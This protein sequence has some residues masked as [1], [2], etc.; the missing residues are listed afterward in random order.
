MRPTKLIIS[1]FGPYASRSEI[2]L[3]KLGTNGLFLITGDTGAGKTTI[4]DAIAFA[5]YGK[6]SGSNRDES[7]LRSKYA[8]P[9]TPT[10]VELTFIYGGKEYRI[11]RNPEYERPKIHGM[12]TTME[13]S[14]AELY[15]P[16][17]P[18]ISGSKEVT[19]AVIDIMGVDRD[20]YTQIAM[21]AQGDFLKLL[22]AT[23]DE[24]KK[25]FQKIFRTHTYYQLQELLKSES[26]KLG[27]EY[28]MV[29]AGIRQYVNGIVCHSEDSLN[30]GI[31]KAK[32]GELTMQETL[33]LLSEL[34]EKESLLEED[35]SKES[36]AISKLLE[37]ITARIA[38]AE[39]CE[40]ARKSIECHTS[41]L[42]TATKRLAE[43][44]AL[45]ESER[46]RA[47]ACAELTLKIAS[48]QAQ[49]DEYSER[50]SKMVEEKQLG[51]QL[52]GDTALLKSRVEKKNELLSLCE[53]LKTEWRSLEGIE[54]DKVKAEAEREAVTKKN[55]ICIELL[56]EL[57]VLS[58]I[59]KELSDD[60]D[61]YLRLRD[62]AEEIKRQY[63]SRYRLYLDG[64]AG[65]LA[66]ELADG[67]ACPV[68]GSFT[69][70]SPAV[71]P[72]QVPTKDELDKSRIAA[73]TAREK[74]AKASEKASKTKGRADEKQK[75]VSE[76]LLNEFGI[77][78]LDT[79]NGQLSAILGETENEIKRIDE[80][81]K[82]VSDKIARRK[83]IDVE[84]SEKEKLIS[85]SDEFIRTTNERITATQTYLESLRE[86]IS[87]LSEKLDFA[88]ATEATAEKRRLEQEKEALELSLK[89]AERNV[90]NQ[91]TVISE[92]KAKISEAEKH[93]E[94]AEDTDIE[95]AREEY[96]SL[97]ER[98]TAL[99]TKIKEIHAR[100]VTNKSSEKNICQ[101]SVEISRIEE[102]WTWIKA[103]SNTARGNLSGKD[104]TML[105]TY[106]QKTYFDRIIARANKRLLIMTGGQYEL[107]RSDKAENKKSQS[108][109][110]L[111]VKDH[112]N[113]TERSVKSLSGGES[114]MAS[115]ALA[116]GLSEEIQASAGGI[117]L[118]TM[119]VDE[120]FGSLDE[121]SLAQ[122]IK[123][124]MS[125]GES[126][127]LVGIISHVRELK[128]SI[129]NQIV[130]TKERSGGSKATIIN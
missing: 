87:A 111:D 69:H 14:N 55:N 58:D 129:S 106:V 11:K 93:L 81:I 86:R 123:A 21:I 25:I 83:A 13:K 62:V 61:E 112:Y 119:F 80:A 22:L 3:E 108:G 50:D 121:D 57:T 47:S 36:D 85:D 19:S 44:T 128:D 99:D 40:E 30:T 110:E 109:L 51:A 73:D 95:A 90:I 15:F 70:P 76:R 32:A 115:L 10:E 4:F 102:R 33:T 18:P 118:D 8:E 53:A 88:N 56:Q 124:L 64:Q 122:A 29:L 94:N 67:K 49:L 78:N 59:C 89:S 113:G 100:I 12:G 41:E 120:G 6:A 74:A 66:D 1:A 28:E 2:D 68:C 37:A 72:E 20:Q 43:L 75:S 101:R 48:I 7:M 96:A 130:V 54:A 63:D 38:S 39:L 104:K 125:L 117:K 127:R 26:D 92:L 42:T 126:N 17:R 16:D 23:T 65:I 98:K 60:R 27:K 77:T 107:K 9:G 82:A 105:E 5:L 24:R 52:E 103:L 114:F 79:A 84:L 46:E 97:K 31:E 91:Q 45:L 116:L 35:I 71:K 34:I